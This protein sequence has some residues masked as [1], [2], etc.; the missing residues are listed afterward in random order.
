MKISTRKLA[1]AAVVGAAYA[2]LTLVLAP[3][4]FGLV[5]FRVSEALCIL[6]AFVRCT[7]WGLW[8]GCAIANL[9]GGYGL[10]DIVFGS[11][12]T[13]GA[14]LYMARLAKGHEHPLGLGRAIAVCLMPVVWNG[15]IV[16]AVIAYSTGAFWTALPLNALQIAGEEALVM[17]IIGLPLLKLLP[18]SAAFRRTLEDVA[19]W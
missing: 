12:A 15:P 2:A 5:Q 14:S 1:A 9:A 17:Y 3:I 4:S 19:R 10:P 18:R 6:P 16:G 7:A 8:A 11:L 13:L